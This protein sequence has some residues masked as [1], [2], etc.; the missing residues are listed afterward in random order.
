AAG[1][2]GDIVSNSI[3]QITPQDFELGNEPGCDAEAGTGQSLELRLVVTGGGETLS[4]LEIDS[5]VL[6]SSMM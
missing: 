3:D 1:V 2:D 5:L 4:T 6:G